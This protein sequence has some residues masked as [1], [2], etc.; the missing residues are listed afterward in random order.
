MTSER[1]LGTN[2]EPVMCPEGYCTKLCTYSGEKLMTVQYTGADGSMVNT[3]MGYCEERYLYDEA[4]NVTV[5][6]WN[7]EGGQVQIETEEPAA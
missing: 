7:T 2:E 1:Y 3:A 4:G 5:T 6:Y